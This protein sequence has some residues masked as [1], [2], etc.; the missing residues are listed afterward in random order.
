V[1]CSCGE[2]IPRPI[3]ELTEQERDDFRRIER[4]RVSGRPLPDDTERW[5]ERKRREEE[6]RAGP[7]GGKPASPARADQ[8]T[9]RRS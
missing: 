3:R 5:D 1:F 7:T 6:L 9:E 2:E 8:P 4:A